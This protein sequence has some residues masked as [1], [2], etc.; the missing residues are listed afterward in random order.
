MGTRIANL[1]LEEQE[2]VRAANRE[3]KRKQRAKEKA[4]PTPSHDEWTSIWST[5]FALQYAEL[6]TFEKQFTL[7]VLQELAT[8]FEDYD[9]IEDILAEVAIAYYCFKK[10]DPPWVRKVR[11]G[12]I[13]GGVF[14][15]EVLGSGLVVGTHRYGLERSLYFAG[16]YRELLRMLDKTFGH[17]G[18]IDAIER[19]CAADVRAELDGTYIYVPLAPP[20]PKTEATPVPQPARAKGEPATQ[21][22]SH[23]IPNVNWFHFNKELDE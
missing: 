13:V 12:T 15:P 20:Q 3:Y 5:T 22:V 11:E 23:R 14:F 18:T 7:R 4:E 6:R 17:V 16:A 19:R 1:P 21:E 10:N 2:R 9:L 8:T